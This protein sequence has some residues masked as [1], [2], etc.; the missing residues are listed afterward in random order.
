MGPDLPLVIAVGVLFLTAFA[1]DHEERGRSPAPRHY[2]PS[3]GG[4][5]NPPIP[6]VPETLHG[7]GVEQREH[8]RKQRARSATKR[9]YGGGDNGSW[10][11]RAKSSG[12]RRDDRNTISSAHQQRSPAYQPDNRGDDIPLGIL[13]PQCRSSSSG[14]QADS[15]SSSIYCNGYNPSVPTWGSYW[16]YYYY[17]PYPHPSMP[18]PPRP[19]NRYLVP[20]NPA[21]YLHP[22]PNLGPGVPRPAEP[23]PKSSRRRTSRHRPSNPQSPVSDPGPRVQ[24]HQTSSGNMVSCGQTRPHSAPE[25]SYRAPQPRS[26]APM[27]PYGRAET[28]SATLPNNEPAVLTTEDVGPCP[29]CCLWWPRT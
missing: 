17:D 21:L 20:M 5:A 6:T 19:P 29:S 8:R 25:R 9:R 12:S 26:A 27:S 11:R 7:S 10:Q 28:A 4:S 16:P 13:H 15:L 23:R 24:S 1:T 2:R 18:L 3:R 22:M 14:S